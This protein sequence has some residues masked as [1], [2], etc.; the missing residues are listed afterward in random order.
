MEESLL[1][2]RSGK[3]DLEKK[4]LF[5]AWLTE[6]VQERAP[7][8]IPVLVGGTA[9]QIYTGTAYAT[10]DIDIVCDAGE[11]IADILMSNGFI[12]DGRYFENQDLGIVLEIPD[13]YYNGRIMP[14]QMDN[15]SMV[16]VS[17]AE[18]MILDRINNY[19]ACGHADDLQWASVMFSGFVDRVD[20]AYLLEKADEYLIR[21]EIED[22]VSEC[23]NGNKQNITNRQVM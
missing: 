21:K 6:K 18:D 9:V 12:R 20:M 10:I 5:L 22:M 8:S 1:S 16:Y 17:S 14:I 11:K 23:L 7:K 3:S 13:Y 15:G 4:M 2:L 19:V